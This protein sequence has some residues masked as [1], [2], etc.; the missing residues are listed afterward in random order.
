MTP[1]EE[2]GK[3]R[4][5]DKD[6]GPD[7]KHI[8]HSQYILAIIR[9]LVEFSDSGRLTTCSYTGTLITIFIE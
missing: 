7:R 1:R 9:G 3:K 6:G 5:R 4:Q 2:K 8:K